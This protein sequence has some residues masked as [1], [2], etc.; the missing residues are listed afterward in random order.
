MTIQLSPELE[1]LVEQD[2]AGGAYASVSDFVARAVT[3][4]HER[5]RWL[6]EQRES[7]RGQIEEG[8]ASAERGDVYAEEEARTQ[9]D[10]K[11]RAHFGVPTGA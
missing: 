7:I 6:S 1:A 11:L 10:R 4:L 8:W 9:V 5:E 3:E 2:V